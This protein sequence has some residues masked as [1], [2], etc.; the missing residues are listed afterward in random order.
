MPLAEPVRQFL[1]HEIAV[2]EPLEMG[3]NGMGSRYRRTVNIP[4]R[5]AT[6]SLIGCLISYATAHAESSFGKAV[7]STLEDPDLRLRGY[8]WNAIENLGRVSGANQLQTLRFETFLEED[9]TGI[10]NALRTS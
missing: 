4:I 6:A 9:G 5:M 10:R 1:L 2:C 3:R 8:G 7:F